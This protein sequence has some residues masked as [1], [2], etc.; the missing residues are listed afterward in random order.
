MANTKIDI[1]GDISIHTEN[2]LPIIK[3]WLYS[4]NEIFVRELA[5][6]AH[7]AI[8]KLR[9][10]A[11]MESLT[12]VDT[13]GKI[14]ITVNKDKK[15]ITI[16]DNGIGM[17]AE[18]VQKY[19]NQ[20]A[21]SGAEEFIEK[22]KDKDDKNQVIGHFG[23][24]FYSSFIVSDL[25]EINT[26]SYKK[27]EPAV[28]WTCDGS[29]KFSLKESEKETV[30]TE[31]ILHV[32]D[33]CLDYLEDAKMKTLVQKYANF[34]PIEIKVGEEVANNQN[35]LWVK[36]P[37]EVTDEEYI[38]FYKTLF[39]FNEE[40][41]FW[42]HLNVD[43]PFNLQGILYFPKLV[44]ELDAKKGKIQLYCQQVFVT[45]EAKDVVPEFLT[46]LQGAV[47]CPEIPLNV[48]RS[49]LQN[50]PYVQKISKHIVKKVA[51]KLN[52]LY[53]KDRETLDKYWEDISPFIK[54][55]MMTN[56]DFYSKAKEMVMFESSDGGLVTVN[57]YLERNKEKHENKVLYCADKTAQAGYVQLCKDQGL[58]VLFTHAVIDSHFIQFLESKNSDTKFVSVDS[59]LTEF[60]KEETTEKKEDEKNPENDKL[61][62]VFK[63]ALGD[64][65]LDVKVEALKTE[66]VPAMVLQPEFVKR[67]ATMNHMSGGM[68]MPQMDMLQFVINSNN[69]TIKAVMSLSEDKDKQETVTTLC[70]HIYDLAKL[71]QK[72]LTG[73]AMQQ[74]IQRSNELVSIIAKG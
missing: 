16:A 63:K 65:K 27:D 57:D 20:I 22:Y 4:E 15:T 40:P 9:K 55:G 17:T 12:D 2:I 64:D 31:I 38:A 28:N 61:I 69:S 35:P 50:D 48:S 41:L 68:K 49:Y 52:E 1:Q 47:D 44:H 21:F 26:K 51:D 10:V 24:G 71:N 43:Y 56:D 53:K 23:L 29:T 8:T 66:A 70:S 11:V 58:E 42:I 30:G 45:D 7:D 3:K 46:L 37:L 18:E 19:I 5:S 39:P 6:N 67:M 34:L 60:L 74:F 73:E 72:P 54:Y 32:N 25:V 14:Q 33:D 59:E 62:E 13:E 36:Q